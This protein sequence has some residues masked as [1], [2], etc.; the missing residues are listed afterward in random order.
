[1]KNFYFLLL[2]V[3]FSCNTQPKELPI[4]G[5][6]ETLDDGTIKYH[7]IPPFSFV[8][9]DSL[10]IEN[11][12]FKNKIYAADFFF[13]SCPSICPKVMKQMVRIA[14]SQENNEKFRL[15]SHTIDPKRDTH[16]V[17]KIYADNLGIDQSKWHFLTGQKD[18][19]LDMADEYY[20]AAYEDPTAPGGFDHSGKILLIDTKGHIRAFCDGTDPDD[21]TQFIKDIDVLMAE[22]DD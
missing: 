2:V 3:T 17:L 13:T 4:I 20:V 21:V 11:D 22:Y 7:T 18:E 14:D 19:L 12:S 9:Q 6:Q 10:K 5:F 8:N 15:V 16:E 1:M